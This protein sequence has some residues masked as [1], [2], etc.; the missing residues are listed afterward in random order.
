MKKTIKQ[1]LE[2]LPEPYRTQAL[3]NYDE[4]FAIILSPIEDVVDALLASFSWNHSKEGWDYWE[5]V[6]LEILRAKE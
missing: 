6:R 2:E 5:N 1:W 3:N 4:G